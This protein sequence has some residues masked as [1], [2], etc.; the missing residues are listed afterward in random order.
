MNGIV[1]AFNA[2]H[3]FKLAKQLRNIEVAMAVLK[4]VS[5]IGDFYWVGLIILGFEKKVQLLK[6][7]DS[8]LICDVPALE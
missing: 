4:P 2:D 3:T 1:E 8:L 6:E 7:Q 5:S